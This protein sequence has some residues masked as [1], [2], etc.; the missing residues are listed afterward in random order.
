M[1]SS[2]L[3]ASALLALLL[4]EAG[5]ER[6]RAVLSESAM[7]T[8]NL[9]EV[10]AYYVRHGANEQ[11]VREILTLLPVEWTDFDVELAIAAGVMSAL[12]QSAGLSAGDRA[13]LAL[14]RHLGLPAMTADRS[15]STVAKTVGIE[16]EFIR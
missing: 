8:V 16:V 7:S 2:V 15:W 13:C 4:D 3:D 9:S 11:S 10:V 14:A 12:T 5:G 1:T 6:V